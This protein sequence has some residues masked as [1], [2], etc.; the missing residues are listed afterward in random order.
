MIKFKYSDKHFA[1]KGDLHIS[2]GRYNLKFLFNPI[3]SDKSCFYF[4][5]YKF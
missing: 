1:Y 3:L 4:E 2:I 5:I